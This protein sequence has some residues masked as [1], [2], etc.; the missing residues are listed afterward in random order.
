MKNWNIIIWLLAFNPI[1]LYKMYKESNWSNKIKYTITALFILLDIIWI[2]AGGLSIA[3]LMSSFFIFLIGLI[4]LIMNLFKKQNKRAS[5]VLVV[6]GLFLFMFSS[7]QVSGE[8]ALA[9]QQEQELLIKEEEEKQQKILEEAFLAVEEAE[10]DKNRETYL[11]AKKIVGKID[12]KST[13]LADLNKRLEVIDQYLTKEE[14][15]EEAKLALEKAEKDKTERNYKAAESLMDHIDLEGTD[16]EERLALVR[17]FIDTENEKKEELIAALEDAEKKKDRES[18]EKAYALLAGLAVSDKKLENRLSK[19]EKEISVEEKRLAAEEKKA[20]AKAEKEKSQV[21]GQLKV[22]YIN[23][24]QGDSTLIELPNG[25]NV[26]IDGA[27]RSNGQTVLN[28]LS[29]LNIKKIDYVIATHPHEDH[30]GGLVNVIKNYDIGKIYMPEKQHT[31]IVFEDLLLAIQAK[32]L[33]INK[34]KAGEA[35]FEEDGLSMNILA[36]SGISGS[37]LNDHSIANRLVFGETA[38]VFTGDAERKSEGNMVNSGYNL[39]ADVL[40]VSHHG[41]DTSSISSF[42]T[43]V[44]PD[45]GIISAGKDNQYGHPHA[46]VMNRLADHGIKTFRTD[47][48]GTIIAT[49]NGKTIE[50]NK[51]ATSITK[52]PS[53]SSSS[54]DGNQSKPKEAEKKEETVESEPSNGVSEEQAEV[55]GT[56]TGSK[57]HKSS[58][59]YLKK[60]KIGLT[61]E[62]AKAQG[63]EACGVCKPSQ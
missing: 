34:A 26:L 29:N 24:G 57:Y 50:F 6:A 2:S 39:S 10:K 11:E 54:S 28:Y 22:H 31:T 4:S 27:T 30:I 14:K 17:E 49:S 9:E 61:L 35:L 52:T 3:L 13:E 48:D 15:F 16:F 47:Q 60:S 21:S 42:L 8:M 44:N 38:F 41:G 62:K 43:K 37:N 63:L 53:D 46:N 5:I 1:G 7:Y 32:G 56:N 20:Q 19:L 40:K 33:P 51:K 12:N 59:R 36:P 58:C 45:Y 55:Y 18:Y 23:V 25:K